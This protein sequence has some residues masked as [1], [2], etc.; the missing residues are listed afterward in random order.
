MEGRDLDEQ[1]ADHP[2]HQDLERGIDV[3]RQGASDLGVGAGRAARAARAGGD[4]A[5]CP[6]SDAHPVEHPSGLVLGQG[7]IEGDVPGGEPHE[8]VPG[9]VTVPGLVAGMGLEQPAVDVGDGGAGDVLLETGGEIGDGEE[10]EHAAEALHRAD[11]REGRDRRI[12]HPVAQE[13][14]RLG[15]V[16][17]A[18]G[19]VV[20][21]DVQP[22]CPEVL[23]PLL[24]H[25]RMA[26][27][28]WR[29]RGET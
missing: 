18:L 2:A 24:F 16:G 22:G 28:R 5:T 4:G 6:R 12:G 8:V 13:Q 27:T 20:E 11:A 9:L 1:Q 29:V 26:G 10:P 17:K 14:F 15:H 25:A 7:V 21:R 19:P 23:H 3:L